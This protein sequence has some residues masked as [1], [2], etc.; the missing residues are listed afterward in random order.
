MKTATKL[1]KKRKNG[2]LI[3]M[4]TK[5]GQRIIN[6]KRKKKRKQLIK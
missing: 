6:L 3:R 1:K 5:S 2:F 4:K